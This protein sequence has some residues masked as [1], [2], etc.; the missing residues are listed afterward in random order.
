MVDFHKKMQEEENK[1]LKPQKTKR[2][3][4]PLRFLAYLTGFLIIS[5]FIFSSSVSIVGNSDNWMGDFNFFRQMGH[6]TN[7]A[8]KKVEGEETDRINVLLLGMGGKGHDGAY[9]TDT[10]ILASLKP[11]EN[12]AVL[13]SIPRDLTIP[14][15]NGWQKINSINAYAEME[16]QGSGGK[17]LTQT[18]EEVFDITIPYYSRVDFQGFVNIVNEMGGVEIEVENTLIDHK[19]PI[20]GRENAENYA[21]RYETLKIEKGTQEMDGELALKYVRSRH[22][23]GIEGSDF[24]RARRQQKIIQAI[25]EEL[26]SKNTFLKPLMISKIINELKDHVSTNLSISEMVSLWEKFKDLNND[27][28]ENKVLESGPNG[29]LIPSRAE[30]GAYILLPKT[31]NFNQIKTFFNNIFQE[32]PLST[33]AEILEK[34]ATIEILNGT[35]INNLAGRNAKN[36]ENYNFKITRTDNSP[37]QDFKESTIYDLTYGEKSQALNLLQNK[38]NAKIASSLPSW[39]KEYISEKAESDQMEKPDFILILGANQ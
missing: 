36:L 18:L 23:L 11:S 26:L 20:M 24:A 39:L 4:H 19:Y 14:T 32:N 3:K 15:K 37:K 31:G 7:S 2:K 22:A 5:F 25:K 38:T 9:L 27:N 35:T 8:D 13:T 21:S 30:S 10:I 12:R 34:T 1:D 6:L 17:A 28:I 16:K 33:K 29:L